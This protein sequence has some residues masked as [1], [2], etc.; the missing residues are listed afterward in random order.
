MMKGLKSIKDLLDINLVMILSEKFMIKKKTEKKLLHY[1]QIE[2]KL[3]N[4]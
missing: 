1:T 4:H 2:I 3:A